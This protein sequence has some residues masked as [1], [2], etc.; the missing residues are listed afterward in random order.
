MS[1]DSARLNRAVEEIA[2]VN[3]LSASAKQGYSCVQIRNHFALE[4]N[5]HVLEFELTLLETLDAQSVV[6]F[7]LDQ[8]LDDHVQIPVF[9]PQFV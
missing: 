6:V 7:A 9:H 2:T 1:L 8:V 5:D 3:G 4:L